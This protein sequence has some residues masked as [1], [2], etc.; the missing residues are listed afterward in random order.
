MD[1]SPLKQFHEKWDSRSSELPDRDI[2]H[3]THEN[4]A[5]KVLEELR[6]SSQ[7]NSWILGTKQF[8]M[9]QL[10]QRFLSLDVENFKELSQLLAKNGYN[11]TLSSSV[12]N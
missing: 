10:I 4:K 6:I 12:E 2:D 3:Q 11:L 8:V 7:V 9:T 1:V 5:I